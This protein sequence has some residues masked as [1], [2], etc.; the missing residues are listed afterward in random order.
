MDFIDTK[1]VREST[2]QDIKYELFNIS[3]H[4]ISL[5]ISFNTN[6]IIPE[7]FKKDLSKEKD[8]S[9]FIKYFDEFLLKSQNTSFELL[10]T[11]NLALDLLLGMEK[12]PNATK[13]KA[14]HFF[15]VYG[16]L[17][18][19]GTLTV[20][21]DLQYMNDL[22]I[23]TKHI[24]ELLVLGNITEFRPF[25]KPI[26]EK[27]EKELRKAIGRDFTPEEQ[28][29]LKRLRSLIVRDYFRL[30]SYT[31]LFKKYKSLPNI[32]VKR[33][34]I[35]KFKKASMVYQLLMGKTQLQIAEE[36][37]RFLKQE[38]EYLDKKKAIDLN[39]RLYTQS[40]LS[41]EPGDSGIDIYIKN[42]KEVSQILSPYCLMIRVTLNIK[43]NLMDLPEGQN[44]ISSSK[45]LEA[46]I[47][48]I[49]LTFEK[50]KGAMFVD[51]G[52][53]IDTLEVKFKEQIEKPSLSFVSETIK[54][55]LAEDTKVYAD[56]LEQV[57][58]PFR[59]SEIALSVSCELL[60][61]TSDKP[62]GAVRVDTN[63]N[64]GKIEVCF[65]PLIA[66][67]LVKLKK[68]ADFEIKIIEE[69]KRFEPKSSYEQKFMK[70]VDKV[71][72]NA[73][74]SFFVKSDKLQNTTASVEAVLR[75]IR[76][77]L[78][79]KLLYVAQVA[80]VIPALPELNEVQQTPDYQTQYKQWRKKKDFKIRQAQKFKE[81]LKRVDSNVF[82]KLSRVTGDIIQNATD[83]K[84]FLDMIKV[85][86]N[87]KL[88]T[89]VLSLN[90]NNNEVREDYQA[91][92]SH[93]VS[94][95]RLQAHSRREK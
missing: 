28:E 60:K 76:K 66:R 54:K 56:S 49:C 57:L 86:V 48:N 44:R 45:A 67:K 61:N 23:V 91:R 80:P 13:K 84:I 64:L 47:K 7:E 81:F 18:H 95:R 40:L 33:R 92:S 4:R 94:P 31:I 26:T 3:S 53:K 20:N 16:L 69:M 12:A 75:I 9:K 8:V 93:R 5:D 68:L 72:K 15:D 25:L 2:S 38:E 6:E 74:D 65:S 32:D 83:A 35:W 73:K 39:D 90:D 14:H 24:G 70:V 21:F 52:F 62:T 79:N 89:F 50:K 88:S 19:L 11:I 59:M 29:I 58:V 37:Q 87:L 27:E 71:Y 82:F 51:V 1:K 43:V 41:I 36:E 34:L 30:Y 10:S 17:L 85:F 55:V 77:F 46:E 22:L 42:F 78:A 63:V